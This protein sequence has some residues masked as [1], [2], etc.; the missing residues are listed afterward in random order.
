[1]ILIFLC[2]YFIFFFYVFII[3]EK[4][5]CDFLILFFIDII[6]ISL[7]GEK[8]DIMEYKKDIVKV[9]KGFS[10]TVPHN[11]VKQ[12]HLKEGFPLVF[13]H[14]LGCN[15]SIVVRGVQG[16]DYTKLNL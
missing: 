10:I 6:Y 12:Y 13:E 14:P 5:L 2:F 11:V 16:L 9:K 3:L 15:D 7:I 8:G 1:M 4:F